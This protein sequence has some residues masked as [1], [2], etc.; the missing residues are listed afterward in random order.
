MRKIELAYRPRMAFVPFHDRAQRWACLICHRRAGK[1]V[2]L[3]NDLII[4]A[5]ECKLPRPQF[6]FVGPTY[7][8]T[9]RIAWEYLKEY[10][11]PIT[12][13]VN[14]TELRVDLVNNGRIFL[15]GSDNADALR[16]LYL[17]G[18]V[19]DEFDMQRPMVWSQ[20]IRPALADRGGWGV[21]AGTPKGRRHLYETWKNALD[22]PRE[23][24][25]M[26]LK[27]SVSG[28]LHPDE[29]EGMR[30]SMSPDEFDQEMECSFDATVQGRI[31]ANY[32]TAARNEGRI[33]ND[34]TYDPAGA[35]IEVSCD[36]GFRD[37]AAFWFW[38]PAMDGF[39][40]LNYVSGAGMDA[41]EWAKELRKVGLRVRTLW[42]PHD[43]KARTMAANSTVIEQFSMEGYGCSLVPK[44]AIR[45]RI[46]AARQ[47]IR[48]CRFAADAC[49]EGIEALENWTYKW[50]E[51][52][53]AFSSEPLHDKFSHGGDSFS[54]G[55][56][57][58][59]SASPVTRSREGLGLVEPFAAAVPKVIKAI[60]GGERSIQRA[61]A[62]RNL[63]R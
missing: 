1:T 57:A 42:L 3:I 28:I 2:A 44:V 8:Q 49:D 22:N 59:Y 15:A 24:F 17:D 21:L 34:V 54:Y 9:K 23:W 60:G 7:A 52:T 35:P 32:I 37:T 31:L 51:E 16:G 6:A 30:R 12:R 39:R 4:G 50:I 36:L 13:A 41:T 19:L 55:G 29:L 40:V 27:S 48:K 56:V 53:G 63:F 46:E 18:A 25:T 43:A 58:L 62:R 10:A 47:I 20:I 33:S 38:Q 11:R 45:D 26:L 5:L 61:Q 14:E